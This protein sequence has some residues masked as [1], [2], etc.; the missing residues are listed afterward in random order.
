MT[1]SKTS[2]E[3]TAP[4]SSG[5]A[6]RDYG[7]DPRSVSPGQVAQGRDSVLARALLLTS[8]MTVACVPLIL[9]LPAIPTQ[10]ARLIYAAA[11]GIGAI[12]QLVAYW[13]VR[14]GKPRVGVY[15]TVAV[16]G[17]L[18]LV[19]VYA[20]D[21]LTPM[22]LFPILGGAICGIFLTAREVA[23]VFVALAAAM[24][25]VAT[26]HGFDVATVAEAL[27]LVIGSGAVTSMGALLHHRDLDRIGQLAVDMQHQAHHDY[28]TGLP[29]RAAALEVLARA[30]ARAQ[31]R[32]TDLCL[33]YLD[34]SEFKGINDIYGH[35]VGDRLLVEVGRRMVDSLR[36]GDFVGRLGGDEF[37]I[38][39][40]DLA[41]RDAAVRLIER[42]L[43]A[44]NEPFAGPGYLLV[45]KAS[46]GVVFARDCETAPL[47]LIG[48]ADYALYQAKRNGAQM[49]VYNDDHAAQ[50]TSRKDIELALKA[51][52]ERDGDE[53][54]VRYQPIID[55]ASGELVSVE[56]LL[57]WE[58]PGVGPVYPNDFIPVAEESGLIMD[59]DF[60]VMRKAFC[61]M[62]EWS[63]QHGLDDLCISVNVSGRH[64]LS[65]GLYEHVEQALAESGIRPDRVVLE[66]TETVLAMDLVRAG[67]RLQRVR[68][69]G[70]RCSIDDFG[71]GYTSIAYLRQLP[72]DEIKIDRSLVAGIMEPGGSEFIELVDQISKHMSA[73]TVAEGVETDEQWE[74]LVQLGCTHLQGY[75]IG[76]PTDPQKLIEWALAR[77]SSD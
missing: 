6:K 18:P 48:E 9:V 33:A 16:Y 23:W 28:L 31:R 22:L 11:C 34:L 25:A 26:A 38:V 72:V 62:A 77:R 44:I 15:A 5:A 20:S 27:F 21:T 70:V 1:R 74:R 65:D 32:G 56:A 58:R 8:L 50:Q 29:N 43:E 51:T 57:W 7:T 73:R 13:L 40:E 46:A 75:Q 66:I 68:K 64:L 35:E 61:Q 30:C 60:W 69:L 10:Q 2:E 41:D 4:V 45:P 24:A 59:I 37:V 53:L 52:L 19:T 12:G 17:V 36:A 42:L 49:V 63:D 54:R 67:E 3:S 39:A 14:R 47:E 76:R 71:T 55:A